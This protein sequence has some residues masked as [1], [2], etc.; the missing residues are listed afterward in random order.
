MKLQWTWREL[1]QLRDWFEK[2]LVNSVCEKVFIPEYPNHPDHYF[3]NEWALRL[4]RGTHSQCFLF[5]LRP[6]E[7]YIDL[8]KDRALKPSNKASH[9]PFDLFLNKVLNGLRVSEILLP[10]G[11]RQFSIRFKNNDSNQVAYTL[12]LKLIPAQPEAY[13]FDSEHRL[14][15]RSKTNESLDHLEPTGK[16]PTTSTLPLASE[17]IRSENF[18]THPQYSKALQNECNRI[19]LRLKIQKQ[20]KKKSPELKKLEQ[21]LRSTQIQFDKAMAEEDYGKWGDLLKA[22]LYLFLSPK[23]LHSTPLLKEWKNPLLLESWNSEIDD[24]EKVILTIDPTLSPHEQLEKYFNLEKRKKRRLEESMIRIQS[25]EEKIKVRSE[26]I[27]GLKKCAIHLE[28]EDVHFPTLEK[29]IKKYCPEQEEKSFSGLKEKERNKL[30]DFSGKTYFSKEGLPLLV[31]RN[32]KENLELTLK[33]AKGN[34]L[35]FHLKGRPG[36]H[37]V[38]LLRERKNASLETL[39]DAAQLCVFYSGGKDWGKCEVD[40]CQ[41]KFVKRIKNSDEVSYTQNKTLSITPD[42]ILLERLFKI[43]EI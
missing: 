35:W 21:N 32:K 42:P 2:D 29:E 13:L 1:K 7:I 23:K 38:I 6:N 41:R 11:D 36:S 14:L 39:L 43:N 12:T 33:I 31:G 8:I 20:L 4:S 30:L 10:E 24:Y 16:T 9:S 19:A 17:K 22:N 25:F 5:S 40:Y 27:Q 28:K 37:V 34:D 18:A 26:W 15:M 3:K